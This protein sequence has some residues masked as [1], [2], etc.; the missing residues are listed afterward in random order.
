MSVPDFEMFDLWACKLS[1]R[2]QEMYDL[3]LGEVSCIFTQL[4]NK[5]GLS[6]AQLTNNIEIK[7]LS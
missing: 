4:K 5:L 7:C 2:T 6:C 1:L 3:K